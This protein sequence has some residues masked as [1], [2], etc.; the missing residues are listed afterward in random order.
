MHRGFFFFIEEGMHI[1]L[2]AHASR[3][4]PVNDS[5][6]NT[7]HFSKNTKSA[8]AQTNQ[9]AG[10]NSP[11]LVAW[12][13]P[14]FYQKL[15]GETTGNR[16]FFFLNA[17]GKRQRAFGMGFSENAFCVHFFFFTSLAPLVAWQGLLWFGFFSL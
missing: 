6:Q 12:S 4:N 17:F 10:S 2:F 15:Q 13:R 7:H 11:C 16:A 8:I 1:Q 5:N 3:E 9:P 14:S